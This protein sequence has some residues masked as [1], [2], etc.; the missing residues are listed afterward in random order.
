M[1][2]PI[3]R[4]TFILSRPSTRADKSDLAT[5]NDLLDTLRANSERCVGMAANMIG[6]N[7]NIIAVNIFGS[8]ALLFNPEITKKSEPYEVFEACLSLD[9]ERTA[10]RFNKIEVDYY[11]ADFKHHRETFIGMTAQIIQHE[12]D[13]CRGII[14]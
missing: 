13:H 8:L 1:I 5:A 4:D 12:V 7:K 2:K 11:D 14:I 3:I 9:G 10:K 6:I